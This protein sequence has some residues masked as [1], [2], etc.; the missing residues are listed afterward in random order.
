MNYKGRHAI[1]SIKTRT[2]VIV[3][4]LQALI[5]K[6]EVAKLKLHKGKVNLNIDIDSLRKRNAPY[7]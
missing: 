7:D 4:A 3:L 2:K 1:S 5:K 6:N